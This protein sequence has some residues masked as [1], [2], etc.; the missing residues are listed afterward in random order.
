MGR[1]NVRPRCKFYEGGEVWNVP[2]FAPHVINFIFYDGGEVSHVLNFAP[3]EEKRRMI[4][5]AIPA[6][7]S[8]RLSQLLWIPPKAGLACGLKD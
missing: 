8:Q 2:N 7:E 1:A 3:P 6:Y 4:Y 5:F